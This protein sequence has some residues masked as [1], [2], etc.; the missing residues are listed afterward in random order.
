MGPFT[1]PLGSSLVFEGTALEVGIAGSP[2]S[3]VQ[4]ANVEDLNI[5]IKSDKVD[6]TNVGDHWH[7]RRPTLND[8]GTI[9]F[10]TFYQPADTT[11]DN[12]SG[13]LL[14]MQINQVLADWQ[15]VLVDTA[16][17]TH[18]FPAYV[19]SSALTA[20]VGDVWH[21]AN[22]LSNDGPPTIG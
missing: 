4:I 5:P 19:T 2:G 3:F 7:R 1:S 14:Y 8:M 9:T 11:H 21:M 13:G 15:V 16:A 20:K 10:K 6:V 12:V 17:T 22:E 18:A